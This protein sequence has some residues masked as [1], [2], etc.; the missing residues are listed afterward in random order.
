MDFVEVTHCATSTWQIAYLCRGWV[1]YTT[2]VFHLCQMPRWTLHTP[3]Y[4]YSMKLRS[5]EGSWFLQLEGF[6]WISWKC[7]WFNN[8]STW[9]M[10][11]PFVSNTIHWLH[12][13]SF[14]QV[15]MYILFRFPRRFA[16]KKSL[17]FTST[18]SIFST[19]FNIVALSAFSI[20]WFLWKF[21]LISLS[22]LTFTYSFTQF[23]TWK[24]YNA[25]GL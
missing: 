3:A 11:L 25:D 21:A 9:F 5:T 23:W 19:S 16:F 20:M 24:V 2:E 15:F 4:R 13:L 7:L 8:V 14:Y 17:P 22:R 12:I 10:M 18:G 6:T 1:R